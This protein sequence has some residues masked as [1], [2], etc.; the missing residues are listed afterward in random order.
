MTKKIYT[1][2]HLYI[3]IIIYMYIYRY[4]CT[5]TCLL[6]GLLNEKTTINIIPVNCDGKCTGWAPIRT[7]SHICGE[8][9]WQSNPFRR[10]LPF[11]VACSAPFA[12]GSTRLRDTK[13]Q[14][15]C[16]RRL[17][18][19]HHWYRYDGLFFALN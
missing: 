19:S 13:R 17:P 5:T 4:M 6:N 9:A 15:D 12:R 2:T 18:G 16:Q 14:A 10:T 11:I 7:N 8:L 1:Y 3:R